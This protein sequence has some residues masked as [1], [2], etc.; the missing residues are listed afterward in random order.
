MEGLS[1][2]IERVELDVN[3]EESVSRG[4][5]EVLNRAGRIGSFPSHPSLPFLRKRTDERE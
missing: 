3:D 1:E 5:K 2:E 4:V